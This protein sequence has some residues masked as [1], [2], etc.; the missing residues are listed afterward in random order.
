[1]RSQIVLT[2][3]TGVYDRKDG[4]THEAFAVRMD[5]ALTHKINEWQ[6]LP[7]Y[8]N[9]HLLS[10]TPAGGAFPTGFYTT[11]WEYD[12]EPHAPEPSEPEQVRHVARAEAELG[13]ERRTLPAGI[14]PSDHDTYFVLTEALEEW[15]SEQRHQ[16]AN[17]PDTAEQ[18]TRWATLA[19]DIRHRIEEG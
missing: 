16:A 3:D 11:V 2:I 5:E 7:A 14:D 17:D 8:E 1:M 9:W 15:A 12:P 10:V 4:E 18:R 6:R 19:D 13:G